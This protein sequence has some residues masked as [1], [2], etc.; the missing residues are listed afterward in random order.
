MSY[1]VNQIVGLATD[2]YGNIG[3]P[4]SLS[5][6]FIS[7]WL[8]DSGNLGDLNNKLCT[9]FYVTGDANITDNG[10][11]FGGEEAAIYSMMYQSNY[12]ASASLSALANGGSFWT[13]IN[14]GD[15][16]ITR[17]DVAKIS[18]S[19]MLMKKDNDAQLRLAIADYKRRVTVP[20]SVDYAGLYSYPSP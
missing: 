15:T 7:G 16:R 13:S 3:Q 1:Y 5:V 10:G 2:I 19:F 20:Q 11:N 4:S 14:E 6:G 12:Y 17:L 9:S 18:Q 8:L